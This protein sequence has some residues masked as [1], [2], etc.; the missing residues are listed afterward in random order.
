MIKS[1]EYLH[2]LNK[3]H[4]TAHFQLVLSVKHFLVN[5]IVFTIVLL[6]YCIDMLLPLIPYPYN[7]DDIDQSIMQKIIYVLLWMQVHYGISCYAWAY[8]HR[9]IPNTNDLRAWFWSKDFIFEFYIPIFTFLIWLLFAF[10]FKGLIGN[11]IV[12][13]FID[14]T[15]VTVFGYWLLKV[16]NLVK[17]KPD[18]L[19]WAKDIVMVKLAVLA[20]FL[21]LVVW[22]FE[23]DGALLKLQLV[24]I[25]G[26]IWFNYCLYLGL[27]FKWIEDQVNVILDYFRKKMKYFKIDIDPYWVD[28]IDFVGGYNLSIISIYISIYLYRIDYYDDE[29]LYISLFS[30]LICLWF[31]ALEMDETWN[32][33]Q[34]QNRIF[35]FNC[36]G[37]P[38]LILFTKLIIW[39]QLFKKTSYNTAPSIPSDFFT[40]DFRDAH[41]YNNTHVDNWSLDFNKN[42]YRSLNTHF[43]T[44]DSSLLATLTVWQYWWWMM[45]IFVMALFNA[46]LIRIFLNNTLYANPK[47]HTSLKSNGRW[48]DLVASLF[49]VFWCTN[50]LINSNY[51]LRVIENQTETGVF[52]LRV[53]GKQWYWVYKFS[54]NINDDVHQHSFIIGRGNKLAHSYAY[55]NY[56]SVVLDKKQTFF[57]KVKKIHAINLTYNKTIEQYYNK[58]CANNRVLNE[59]KYLVIP[60]Y[61]DVS[62]Q[63]LTNHLQFCAYKSINLLQKKIVYDKYFH[64][65]YEFRLI[66]N[67]NPMYDDGSNLFNVRIKHYDWYKQYNR[68]FFTLQQQPKKNWSIRNNKNIIKTVNDS[69]KKKKIIPI[70]NYMKRK[71]SNKLRMLSTYNTLILP[72]N[73]N[74][75]VITNSFDVV[76]SWFVPGLG[77]K[78]DCVPGR[79]THYSLKID[80]AG[81]YYGHC[82]EVC[83]RF[84]HHMPIK[85]IALPFNQFLYYYDMYYVLA[86]TR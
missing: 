58:F 73:T 11:D 37:I 32:Y 9:E 70:N 48:G 57:K 52:T 86:V 47:T 49:P 14:I 39:L 17:H 13:F 44:Y 20:V 25:I 62:M 71:V 51:I 54:V 16:L 46:L 4:R 80:R 33:D 74:I 63:K 76:H 1:C 38:F 21:I 60:K 29:F 2:S 18:F 77:L 45:F 81:I 35:I 61:L 19:I 75:T 69:E 36:V 22:F 28:V 50:I 30:I 5:M 67:K 78:F 59:S 79:S 72:I 10:V 3:V 53:R 40:F 26:I 68:H 15:S 66:L 82:A 43:Q 7:V 6:M 23:L 55:R 27:E 85:I 56:R 31:Y 12:S 83:G 42:T 65:D 64:R 41:K 34:T 84:H 8:I 24:E